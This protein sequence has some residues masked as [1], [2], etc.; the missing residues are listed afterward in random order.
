MRYCVTV[1]ERRGERQRREKREI[2]LQTRLAE[3]LLERWQQPGGS[4]ADTF[5]CCS[6]PADTAA[7]VSNSASRRTI[8]DCVTIPEKEEGNVLI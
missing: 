1:R 8:Y 6:P 4:S 3:E 5:S 7:R 2:N